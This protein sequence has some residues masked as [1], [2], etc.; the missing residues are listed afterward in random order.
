MNTLCP[1]RMEHLKRTIEADVS[2]GHYFGAVIKV[3]RGSTV[4]LDE[5]IGFADAQHEKPLHQDSVFS[6]FSTTKAFFNVLTL[7]AIELGRFALT[8]R[9][10]DILPEFKGAP[11]DRITFTHLLTHTTGMPGVWVPKPDMYQGRQAELYAA[12]VEYVHGTVEPGERCDYAPICNHVLMA[13]ALLRV[14]PAK[15]DLRTLLEEDLLRPLKM[16]DTALG[17]RRDLKPRHVIPDMRGTLPIKLPARTLEGPY[18]LFE[19]EDTDMPH[20]GCVSTTHNV[21]RFAEMLRGEGELEGARILSPRMIQLAR[22][23]WTG[24]MYNEIYRGVALRANWEPP[25]A[26]MGLGFNVRGEG[27][28]HHQ[29]GTLTTPE[30]FG[31]YGAGSSVYWIDPVL[32]LT[33]VCLTAGLLAQAPNIERFQKLA[34]IAVSAAI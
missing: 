5:A 1:E 23:N 4:G 12:V 2:R 11:R 34:D 15:R 8:T 32:D 19:E 27:I 29:L 17:V 28:V 20:V 7:R 10:S 18:A 30:C 6:I 13:E 26:Y 24:R 25:P 33:F 31:N 14:D 3:S 16:H 22:R 9:V 21:W